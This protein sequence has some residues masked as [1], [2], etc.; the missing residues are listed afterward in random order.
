MDKCGIFCY[1]AATHS[2][3]MVSSLF[4][5]SLLEKGFCIRF[6]ELMVRITVGCGFAYGELPILNSLNGKACIL[7]ENCSMFCIFFYEFFFGDPRSC[8]LW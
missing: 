4:T 3:L 7:S 5:V 6:K 2:M 8:L 1:Y